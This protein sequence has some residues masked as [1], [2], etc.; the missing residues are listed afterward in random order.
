MIF[1]PFIWAAF[2]ILGC[3]IEIG[4]PGLF[5]FLSFACGASVAAIGSALDTSDTLQITLFGIATCISFF[6]LKFWMNKQLSRQKF[7]T[8]IDALVGK[9]AI[10]IESSTPLQRASVR[11]NGDIWFVYEIAEKPLLIHDHVDIIDVRGCHLIV[12]KTN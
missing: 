5:L 3:I 6:I 1:T 11:I 7:K 4:T 2:A 12:K 9:K 10:V 8:N